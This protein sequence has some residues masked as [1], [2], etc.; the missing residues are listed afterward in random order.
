MGGVGG[1]GDYVALGVFSN[2]DDRE[3]AEI[4][5]TLNNH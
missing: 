4:G 5:A 3:V 2:L 1:V